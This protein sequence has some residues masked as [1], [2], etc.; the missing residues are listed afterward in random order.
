[1]RLAW[2]VLRSETFLP[3]SEGAH[4]YQHSPPRLCRPQN[5]TRTERPPSVPT[6]PANLPPKLRR[7]ASMPALP[8][9]AMTTHQNISFK[10]HKPA[11]HTHI[12][13]KSSSQAPKAR[14]DTSVARQGYDHPPKT[15]QGLKD[16]RISHE[17]V[18]KVQQIPNPLLHRQNLSS[19]ICK[20]SE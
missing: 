18:K 7:S 13:R 5:I 15:S 17:T 9:R 12:T 4:Q 20:V 1:M 16:R 8:A 10:T 19:N 3:S 11:L 14:V 2:S 6:Q